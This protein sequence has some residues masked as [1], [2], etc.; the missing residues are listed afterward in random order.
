M[1]DTVEML[2]MMIVTALKPLGVAKANELGKKLG[3]IVNDKIEGS[4]IQV[5]DELKDVL[6][7]LL[8]GFRGELDVEG[9]DA[10]IERLR[11]KP[12]EHAHRIPE[13]EN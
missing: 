7:A 5:D 10:E 11:G 9:V 1:N 2:L 13:N 8:D 6:K 4:E 3:D 12:V